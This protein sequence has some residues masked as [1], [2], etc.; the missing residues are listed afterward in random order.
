MATAREKLDTALE[1]MTRFPIGPVNG[2]Q[3]KLVSSCIRAACLAVLYG[4]DDPDAEQEDA[5]AAQADGKVGDDLPP[6][7]EPVSLF[8]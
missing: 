2:D 5:V 4:D 3:M 7:K 8:S 1:P 6:V